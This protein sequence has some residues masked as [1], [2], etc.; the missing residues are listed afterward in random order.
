MLRSS[1]P[2]LPSFTNQY[3]SR[4]TNTKTSI[5]RQTRQPLPK[6]WYRCPPTIL[7]M[8]LKTLLTMAGPCVRMIPSLTSHPR[9][10]SLVVIIRHDLTLRRKF[11][12]SPRASTR[13]SVFF[14]NKF[15]DKTFMITRLLKFS[16]SKL[17][18]L[19]PLVIYKVTKRLQERLTSSFQ[20]SIMMMLKLANAKF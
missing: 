1:T 13:V 17:V 12:N 9:I 16:S 14:H 7:V 3:S 20:A 6:T 8:T 10:L 4:T 2:R 11:V 18:F 15:C 19:S 5:R